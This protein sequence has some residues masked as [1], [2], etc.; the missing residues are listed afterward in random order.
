MNSLF[1]STMI[2]RKEQ[3]F[4]VSIA[5]S[6]LPAA[7]LISRAHDYLHPDEYTTLTGAAQHHYLLGRH[8]AK[9]AAV[10][11]TQANPTSICITPGV[12]GQPV[13]YCPVDSN[14]QVSIAHTRN[15]AT[16]IV[17]PEWHPMAIDIEAITTDK[18]IPGLL[19]AEARLFASL[20]YSQAAWQ[21]LLWTAKEALSKVLK[22]GLTTAMEIFSVAAIQVQGDFIVSTFTNF[23][24][25]KAISWIAGNMAWAIV[26]PERSQIDTNALE[27]LSGIKSNF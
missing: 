10:D 21:L 5:I 15:S 23:A 11:Y 6:S 1:L 4:P 7:A 24:Q 25:Y 22:T 13:L 12:F 20:S 27:V 14:I 3:S 17:F 16:A 19:P 9:L 2:S 8:A 26:L 18:E